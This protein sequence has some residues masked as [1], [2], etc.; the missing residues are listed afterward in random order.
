MKRNLF[1]FGLACLALAVLA[2]S[3]GMN[4]SGARTARIECRADC[5][6]TYQ[7]TLVVFAPQHSILGKP[8]MSAAWI[9]RVLAAAHS[10]AV[11]TGKALYTLG[12]HYGIDP[13]Y[14]LAFFHH[15][16][17][18]GTMGEARVTHSLGNERC[19][20]DRPCIDRDRGGYA[21][22]PSWIDGYQQWYA[23]ML[24]GYVR[25]QVTIPIVHH[26]CSTLEQILPIYA[27]SLDGNDEQAYL[28]AVLSDVAHW[29]AGQW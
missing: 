13:V 2:V 1:L 25:G 21:L 9:D 28:T 15:E 19:I 23:L 10:P 29:R 4:A 27:P 16:S 6:V 26:P 8:T 5:G 14:A 12:V 24:Y 3:N 11:G 17:V 20:Q 22:F 7:I 18:Y